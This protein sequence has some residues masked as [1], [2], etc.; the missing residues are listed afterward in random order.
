MHGP[1]LSANFEHLGIMIF[2]SDFM[3]LCQDTYNAPA[4]NYYMHDAEKNNEG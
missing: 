1:I 2:R 3:L 4:Y